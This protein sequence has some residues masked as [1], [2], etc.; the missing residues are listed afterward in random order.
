MKK[1]IFILVATV[2]FSGCLQTRR[3]RSLTENLEFNPNAAPNGIYSDDNIGTGTNAISSSLIRDQFGSLYKYGKKGDTKNFTPDK[4]NIVADGKKFRIFVAKDGAGMRPM[5]VL[6][7][8][9]NTSCDNKYKAYIREILTFKSATYFNVEG[10]PITGGSY[11]SY[12][13][14]SATNITTVGNYSAF[15]GS[16][17]VSLGPLPTGTGYADPLQKIEFSVDAPQNMVCIDNLIA[18]SKHGAAPLSYMD[19]VPVFFV[20]LE[21]VE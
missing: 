17:N 2:L 8:R 21:M 16:E 10:S 11:V 4:V 1:I 6:K 9:N 20:E 14:S 12:I 18:A 7:A 15:Y 5:F 13:G 3:A 19:E